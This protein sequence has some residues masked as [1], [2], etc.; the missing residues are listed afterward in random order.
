MQRTKKRRDAPINPDEKGIEES[1][2][3]GKVVDPEI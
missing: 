1:G 3:R 2:K